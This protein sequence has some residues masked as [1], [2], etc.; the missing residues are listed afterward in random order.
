MVAGSRSRVADPWLYLAYGVGLALVFVGY[1]SPW[2]PHKT[3]A[4][5]MTGL[6][7][8]EFAKFFPEVESGVVPISR[9]LFYCPLIAALVLLALLSG[10]S[11]VLFVRVLVPLLLAALLL[12]ALFPFPVVEAALQTLR[13][14][15]PFTLDPDYTGQLTLVVVGVVLTLLSPLACR[16]PR[17]AW[18]ILGALLALAGA[19]PALWQ[20]TLLRPLVTALYGEP[21]GLGWGPILCAVGFTVLLI[22]GALG[23]AGVATSGLPSDPE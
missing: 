16:L 21:L 14:R 4:L 17:R 8:A 18:G 9:E 20:F 7:L 10:R 2:V 5:A 1:F 15:V 12:G 19:V 3:A 11:A 23:V 13:A 6:E 22:P